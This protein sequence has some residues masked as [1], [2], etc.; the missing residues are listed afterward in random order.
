MHIIV[1]GASSFLGRAVVEKLKEHGHRVTAFRH[2]FNEAPPVEV[3]AAADVWVHF[4]WAGAGSAGRS[5]PDIQKYNL[6]MSLDA[7]AKAI[8]SGCRKFVFAG[9]QAEYGHAQD[10]GPK[11]EDGPV[12]PVSE[13]GAAKEL[14]S[15]MAETMI[16]GYNRSEQCMRPMRYVHMRLF[17]VYGPGDHSSS[18]V[19]S[20]IRSLREGEGV[21]LGPCTQQWNYLYIDDAADAV[22]ILCEKFTGGIYNVGSRDTRPLKDYVRELAEIVSETMSGNAADAS[23]FL[24]FGV[25]PDNAEG[26]ADLSPDIT[27]LS[28]M[29]FEPKVCF[30]EGIR[31]MI[32]SPDRIG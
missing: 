13:Y 3:P 2:S 29:G 26:P 30:A 7:V 23:R 17:S 10:G 27:K 4:A 32:G 22:A 14:F 15:H 6:D 31:R 28:L 5:D 8:E 11:K 20:L 1:T 24:R 25:R 12:A 18:L 19:S 9:S 16:D 21:D